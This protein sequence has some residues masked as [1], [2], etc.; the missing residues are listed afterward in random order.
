MPN[1]ST[2]WSAFLSN[3][4]AGTFSEE[5]ATDLDLQSL[6]DRV[7]YSAG[8][9]PVDFA[10]PEI[11][12][13]G[14]ETVELSESIESQFNFVADAIESYD[15]TEPDDS[16]L[17]ISEPENLSQNSIELVLVDTSV[18]GYQQ[19]VDDILSSKSGRNIELASIDGASN[20]VRQITDA[21]S[22]RSNISA[23]HLVT[24]GDDGQLAL[25]NTLL[26]QDSLAQYG[27]EIESWRDSLAHG[28]DFLIYGCN[29]SES[30][31]GE[32][33]VNEL[34]DLLDA[35]VAASDDITGHDSLGGDW[36][37]E[38]QIGQIDS[39]VVFSVEILTNWNHS[40]EA[41]DTS[42][43][44]GS[45]NSIAVNGN[46][47]LIHAFTSE[48]AGQTD[49]FYGRSV[50]T[51]SMATVEFNAVAIN[52]INTAGN[53][54]EVSVAAAE[55]GNTVFVWTSD[56]SGQ[57]SVYA[58]ILDAQGNDVRLAFDALGNEISGEF[59]VSGN[60]TN[61]SVDI[62]DA[63]NFVVAWQST[64][65]AGDVFASYFN[66]EG[67][68]LSHTS[69]NSFFTDSSG[70]S[71]DGTSG[72]QGNADVSLNNNGE[73]VVAW[74]NFVSSQFTS[75]IFAEKFQYDPTVNNI[76]SVTDD[77]V[78]YEDG[79]I[80]R[81]ADVD[82]SERGEF[83][84]VFTTDFTDAQ[85][86]GNTGDVI[87][88][89]MA[90]GL[91]AIGTGVGYVAYDSQ[92]NFAAARHNATNIPSL[93]AF[94]P[95]E[96]PS[97]AFLEDGTASPDDNQIII[98]WQGQSASLSDSTYFRTI[99]FATSGG[100]DDFVL[101]ANS[102]HVAIATFDN[103]QR[104][105]IG[106]ETDDATSDAYGIIGNPVAPT[107]ASFDISP[108][109][110]L[111]TNGGNDAFFVSDGPAFQGDL[112]EFTI[113][114]TL[115]SN[116]T[117][118]PQP[119]PLL[120]YDDFL[121]QY[122]PADGNLLVGLPGSAASLPLSPTQNFS[123]DL[124][125]GS[126]HTIALSFDSSGERWAVYI[127]GNEI[128]EGS[129]SGLTTSTLAGGGQLVVGQDSIDGNPDSDVFYSG[130]IHDVQIWDIGFDGL[131]A[132]TNL[133]VQ[134]DPDDLPI[135]L[136]DNWQFN[137]LT[138]G[139]TEVV[140]VI[141]GTSS[142]L[143]KSTGAAGA[144]S[145]NAEEIASVYED[146]LS[147][148]VVATFDTTSPND[149]ETFT[150]ALTDNAGNR[151]QIDSDTGELRVVNANML[152]FETDT[153]HTI[154]IEATSSFGGTHTEDYEI[155]VR[156]VVE[157]NQGPA[158]VNNS[159]T[160][161]VFGAA[162]QVIHTGLLQYID[163]DDP[164]NAELIEYTLISVPNEGFLTVDGGDPL[165][166]GDMFTQQ[167]INNSL[168]RFTHT[169]NQTS[170]DGFEFVVSDSIDEVVSNLE[171]AVINQG[172]Q[173]VNNNSPIFTFGDA[174]QRITTA[175][176][177]YVDPDDPSNTAAQI[178][179]TLDSIPAEGVLTLDGD[180]LAER[181]TFTQQ[182]INDGLLRFN[183]TGT[184]TSADEFEFTVSDGIDEVTDSVNFFVGNIVHEGSQN[185]FG[186]NSL[187]FIAGDSTATSFT[188]ETFPE[189]GELLFNGSPLA[190][191][192]PF[193]LSRIE[194]D[195]ALL[196]YRHDGSETLTDS[197]EVTVVGEDGQ[198]SVET[199]DFIILPVNDIPIVDLDANDSAANMRN[200]FVSYNAGDQIVSVVPADSEIR[201]SD[202]NE[203][204]H[205]EVFFQSGFDDGN[206]EVIRVDGFE[207]RRNI[208]SAPV[209]TTLGSTTFLITFNGGAIS[210]SGDSGA[211][212]PNDDLDLLLKTI[213][214]ENESNSPTDGRRRILIQVF[215]DGGHRSDPTHTFVD[216]GGNAPPVTT[217]VTLTPIAEDSG[218][219]LITQNDLLANASDPEG[220]PLVAQEL[221]I[222]PG[223]AGELVDNGDGTWTY[224]PAPDDD[225]DVSFTYNVLGGVGSAAG[226]ATLDITPQNDA[227]VAVND[228]FT[229]NEDTPYTATLN[230][231]DLLLNDSDLDGD[232]LTCLLYT[233][234]SP[235]DAT[236]SRMPSS[237]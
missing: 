121:I 109:I 200:H 30:E 172:P 106:F 65:P 149:Q 177:Q 7:L 212:I 113:Q 6:E 38:Y 61:A 210:V 12:E 216:I 158:L 68:L 80:N 59:V 5:Q 70:I 23:I 178:E 21:L 11:V 132:A 105:T 83:V 194:Y 98:A 120:S 115:S 49:V 228:A 101:S 95:Q 147:N 223:G 224:T 141:H 197:F 99:D 55:N 183:H 29:V 2:N 102:E 187:F 103:G 167:Q 57:D 148:S 138:S 75:S 191:D 52:E 217:P 137:D 78:A 234:P 77:F 18:E 233:S 46:A 162:N 127:N 24:H 146:A 126:Q 133:N 74:D 1:H 3:W 85:K 90:A 97:V 9:V 211:L 164:A 156:D 8:P 48:T 140:E 118:A 142:L 168:L 198:S 111:N 110:E 26:T 87:L 28:A 226:T 235:R 114:V 204:R 22:Q 157:P 181:D 182:Q 230:I 91:E 139:A 15:S 169:G 108:G 79:S 220:D 166:E 188:I 104:F 207:F 34:S 189:N 236:L 88:D 190:T 60:A 56:H 94:G 180:I 203:F 171:F 155:Q 19:L 76:V 27:D 13:T 135:G 122:S 145:G 231:N 64:G 151:F 36:E 214:Y 186:N 119:V 63:G 153:S 82:I 17:V 160:N 193:T 202:S 165:A 92:N 117:D 86:T 176:L 150:Y 69:V 39:D 45:A 199:V 208:A 128:H 50:V 96:L 213:T 72:L 159:T 4:I 225:T 229:T 25:G 143:L 73:F 47:E 67:N 129:T 205:L 170:S 16:P 136:V 154:T 62:D 44:D 51:D 237:A 161:F 144:V 40:L 163:P 41:V 43:G 123:G 112:D 175:V 192:A 185:N 89:V 152:D 31:S 195:Q 201:D 222:V 53:Q 174:N 107:E 134:I 221:T 131:H 206:N 58:R 10:Q 125:D 227:P 179:Y 219:L 35:D 215:D 66:A 84:L 42:S 124:F 100:S 20:G 218:P 81:N 184:Q 93:L 37:F 32:A 130:T 209:T 54:S 173:L 14:L 71:Q 33:F 116:Q 196:I 232:T